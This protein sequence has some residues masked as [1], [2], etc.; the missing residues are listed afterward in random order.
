MFER[1]HLSNRGL[2]LLVIYSKDIERSVEFYR[3]LELRFERHS[4]PPC[5]DHFA[6]IDGDCVF[7]ICQS[8][9]GQQAP[10]PMTFGFHVSSVEQAIERATAN[11][12]IL[13]R[14]P[15]S[16]EWG[17]SATVADPDGHYVLLMEKPSI[18]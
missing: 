9:T 12:G 14:S 1:S 11:G 7:E 4:H 3:S 17:R 8:D 13:K 6:T 16:A 15:Y 5:G 10:A 18:E 2:G